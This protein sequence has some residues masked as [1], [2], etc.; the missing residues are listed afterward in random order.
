MKV[1]V[2]AIAT[3]LGWAA[4]AL[5]AQPNAL[6]TL[7]KI[8]TLNNADVKLAQPVAFEATVVY[9]RGYENLLFVQDGDDAIFVRSPSGTHL[10]VGDRILIRGKMQASFRPLVIGQSVSLI[11]HGAAPRATP[12]TFDELIRAQHDC[13]LVSVHAVVRAADLVVSP[14]A[15]IRSA[16]LQLVTEGG[17]LE[18]NIE[19]DDTSALK[20]L[21]DAEVEI[22]GATAGKFDDKM[23]Q[24][25]IVL[26]VSGLT[27]IKILKPAGA[28]RWLLPVTPMDRILAV[29]HMSDLTPRVRVEGI[30]TYYQPGSSIVLQDGSKSL[31]I[32]THTR[33]PLQIGDQAD[34]TGFPDAH[35]R[36]LTL[37]DGEI[38][39]R[40][41]FQPVRPLPARWH[42]LGYWSSNTADGHMYDLVS[43]E[44]EVETEVREASQD[45]YVL[46][47]DGRLFTAIYRHPPLP[48]ALP[49]MT[50]IPPG[51]RIRVI[52]I[53]VIEQ[54]ITVNPGEEAPFNIL[55]RSFD[56]I[57][58]VAS[59]SLLN[60]RNLLFLVGLLL[61]VVIFGGARTLV[62]ERKVRRK[63]AAA[64]YIERRRSSIFEDI[65]GSRPVDEILEQI[66]E[67]T[68][69]RLDGAPCW[70]QLNDGAALGNRPPK[71]SSL[72]IVEEVIP[73][74]SGPPL[75]VIVA[76]FDALA[77]PRASESEALSATAALASVAIE[78]RRLYSDLRRRSEFDQLTDIHNRFSL[79]AHL[80]SLM[81]EARR[82]TA[83]FG[84]IYIDLDKFKEVNDQ[85]G[86]RVG[87]CYL[88]EA[89]ARMKGQLRAQDILA[90][91]GG[92]EFAVLVSM[93]SSRADAEEIAFR[94]NRCFDQPFVVEGCI[95]NGS[96][97]VG[98]AIFP[99]DASTKDGLLSAADA[100]M[101]IAKNTKHHMRAS[102]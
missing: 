37:T 44:S 97:S 76:A 66:T 85:Y 102:A 20:D 61:L 88:Q 62:I 92:D 29:Y 51:S 98:L 6:T 19:T 58:V 77:K 56:D 22:T 10:T 91:L 64:A 95:L 96:A 74:R 99:Q 60:I 83:I 38:Q 16:R 25:G 32:Q 67:L 40:Q 13:L 49:A 100:V 80:D 78:T 79:E 41:I 81:D 93:V 33:E 8:H 27:N 59:P 65:N 73:A 75:G 82:E 36:L 101:Y 53:C 72:R 42:Q 55:L 63:T 21:V 68:S 47:S 9:S 69:F 48:S 17:H 89:A 14:M 86:H 4:T 54:A 5:A 35:D 52:G 46:K 12:A 31:W 70:C 34:A 11:R 24:T 50:R 71:L 28:N 45:E 43:I 1:C 18:A 57:S 87:D 15:P 7:R 90:R 23:Q 84:L 26:Y 3:L 39:D 30:I 94:L 2:T